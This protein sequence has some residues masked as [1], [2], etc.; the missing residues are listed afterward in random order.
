MKKIKILMIC[1]ISIIMLLIISPKVEAKSYHIEDMNI[2]ATVQDDGN[3]EIE[4]TLEYSFNG[5]YNGIFI[6]I[7]T[8]Y[9]DND[10]II[11]KIDDSIYGAQGIQVYSVSEVMKNGSSA[12]YTRVTKANNGANGVYITSKENGLYQLKVFSPSNNVNKIF[13]VKYIL[14]NLCVKHEDVGELYY[15]FI[16][17]GWECDIKNLNIDIYL[18]NNKEEIK[19][20]GHGPDNGMSEIINNTHANFKVSNVKKGQ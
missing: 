12:E 1:I 16:G 8:E 11:E 14:K 17:G 7:P 19:I 10:G 6:T 4:H 3:V 18:P 5:S 20:W 2:K 13:K 9:E 15:N